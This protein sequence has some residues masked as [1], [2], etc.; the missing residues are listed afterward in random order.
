MFKLFSHGILGMNA[1]NLK[2]IRTKNSRESMSLADSKLKTKHF[3]TSRGIPFAETYVTLSSQQELQEFSLASLQTDEFVIKPNRG[4]QG[5][6]ILIVRKVDDAYIIDGKIWSE[7][8]IKLHMVDILHGSFSLHGSHDT[9]VIEE[10]LT[11]G[12]EFARY[13]RH[14]LADIRIIVYNY[15]PMTAM[16][17][18]PTATSGGKANLAQ[19][20][21]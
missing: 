19:G 10:L 9:V 16:I 20:G 7:D 1:R 12:K 6:G 21:I 4:S 11:P 2:Y 14:G 15:V 8:D 18:M 17:R 5:K 13:C 3:L